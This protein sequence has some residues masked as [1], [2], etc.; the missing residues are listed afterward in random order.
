L[1]RQ[2]RRYAMVTFSDWYQ[3]NRQPQSFARMKISESSLG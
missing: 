2:K 3:N 1:V